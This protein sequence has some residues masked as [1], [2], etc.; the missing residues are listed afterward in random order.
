M[1]ILLHLLGAQHLNQSLEH[2]KLS[3]NL[4]NWTFDWLQNRGNQLKGISSITN[5]AIV[6]SELRYR[7]YEGKDLG[8]RVW[9]DWLP[10][11]LRHNQKGQ[12]EANCW[13][14]NVGNNVC[15]REK[16]C[17]SGKGV[18][19]CSFRWWWNIHKLFSEQ[20]KT[21]VQRTERSIGL[22]DYLRNILLDAC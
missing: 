21:M 5:E 20:L 4:A 13:V 14:H 7:D 12:S 2:C 3:L 9:I 18:M 8:R 6:K 16:H 22:G 11:V 15:Q 17:V 10:F 1:F 19:N